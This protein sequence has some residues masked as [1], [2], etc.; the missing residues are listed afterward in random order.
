M[1]DIYIEDLGSGRREDGV[2]VTAMSRT[3]VSE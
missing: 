2:G 1:N 3:E